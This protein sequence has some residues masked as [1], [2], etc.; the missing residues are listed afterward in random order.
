[1]ALP[2]P[3][4][5]RSSF[6]PSVHAP[7]FV[8]AG[9]PTGMMSQEAAL[10]ASQGSTAMTA[11]NPPRFSPPHAYDW[12]LAGAQLQARPP[13]HAHGTAHPS[14]P[15]SASSH[16]HPAPR[17]AHPGV[18]MHRHAAG[19]QG[20]EAPSVSWAETGATDG[21]SAKRGVDDSGA[22]LHALHL[23]SSLV[24]HDMLPLHPWVDSSSSIANIPS[25]HRGSGCC[26]PPGLHSPLERP[27]M[28]CHVCAAVPQGPLTHACH[29]SPPVF[30]PQGV[31]VPGSSPLVQCP[32]CSSPLV[33]AAP[34]QPYITAMHRH[35][36][37]HPLPPSLTIRPTLSSPAI[38]SPTSRPSLAHSLPPPTFSSPLFPPPQP[39]L[40]RPAVVHV[41]A[42]AAPTHLIRLPGTA[43]FPT[44]RPIDIAP[45][46]AAAPAAATPLPLPQAHTSL[47]EH[48]Y[49][50]KREGEGKGRGEQSVRERD[51]EAQ[52]GIGAHSR[53]ESSQSSGLRMVQDRAPSAAQGGPCAAGGCGRTPAEAGGL[54]GVRSTTMLTLTL[55]WTAAVRRGATSLRTRCSQ[56]A[57]C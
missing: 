17:G 50:K 39:P 30:P 24:T 8:P 14:R 31:A 41:N 1:M 22:S 29:L 56:P 52:G 4:P 3:S 23:D 35:T 26:V 34:P 5:R 49:N 54:A 16:L 9:R 19:S 11:R 40:H 18:D 53:E 27:V 20:R 38:H 13:T 42:A 15:P 10:P 44:T 25:N 32:A 12:P 46:P 43:V 2:R 51:C 57:R 47:V 48:G 6:V 7:E 28:Q 37:L 45:P 55:T 33:L 21:A 36:S